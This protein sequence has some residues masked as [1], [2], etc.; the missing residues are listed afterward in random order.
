M[1][2]AVKYNSCLTLSVTQQGLGL[3]VLIPFR[4]GHPTLLVPWSD[5][6]QVQEKRTPLLGVRSMTAMLGTPPTVRV[7]LPVWLIDYVEVADG[8]ELDQGRSFEFDSEFGPQWE[9]EACG[10]HNDPTFDVCW[11]CQNAN[12]CR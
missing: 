6:H 2:G 11:Q 12:L 3:S 8:Y 4:I 9:C 10:E 5:F 1:I 7:T